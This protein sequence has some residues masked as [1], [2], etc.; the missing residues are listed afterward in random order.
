METILDE[1]DVERRRVLFAELRAQRLGAAFAVARPRA[2]GG[3]V[4][5]EQSSK[6]QMQV[7][8]PWRK[9]PGRGASY[10]GGRVRGASCE[11]MAPV[12]GPKPRCEPRYCG[13]SCR[14]AYA[15]G[16]PAPCLYG[17]SR[18]DRGGSPFGCHHA[19]PGSFPARC[20]AASLQLPLEASRC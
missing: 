12:A 11:T 20:L 3:K 9:L 1:P 4:E 2:E 16:A 7:R 17:C 5:E 13:A 10:G 18:H 8:V 14:A 6:P 19:W 15:A